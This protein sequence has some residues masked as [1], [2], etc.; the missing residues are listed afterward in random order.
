MPDSTHSL[1][2][3]RARQQGSMATHMISR[4]PVM[5]E[6]LRH[7]TRFASSSFNLVGRIK[8]F[9]MLPCIDTTVAGQLV[10]SSIASL[11]AGASPDSSLVNF[12][13]QCETIGLAGLSTASC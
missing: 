6:G 1:Q 2:V 9:T 4:L 8:A 12:M 10:R 13:V 5:E 7:C 11:V 3:E